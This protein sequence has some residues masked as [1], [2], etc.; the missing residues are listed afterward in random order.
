M[1]IKSNFIDTGTTEDTVAVG[2]HTH[3]D[4]QNT[5]QKNIADGYAGLDSN[6]KILSDQLPNISMIGPSGINSFIACTGSNTYRG[7]GFT[8][9]SNT[10][11]LTTPMTDATFLFCNKF[12][13]FKC[14]TKTNVSTF[15]IN[16]IFATSST[17]LGIYAREFYEDNSSSSSEFRV[18]KYTTNS[19]TNYNII[20]INDYWLCVAVWESN[21]QDDSDLGIYS[22]SVFTTNL[23]EFRVNSHT[24]GKQSNPKVVGISANSYIVTW[25]SYIQDDY[26]SSDSN[27]YAR[28]CGIDTLVGTEFRVSSY[29]TDKQYSAECCS[30]YNFNGYVITWISNRQDGFSNGIYAQR[31]SNNNFPHGTE[32]RVNSYTYYDQK[33]HKICSLFNGGY[34]IVWQSDKQDESSTGIYSKT[35]DINNNIVGDL[36]YYFKGSNYLS[37]PKIGIA[38]FGAG[39]SGNHT[40]DFTI[41]FWIYFGSNVTGR[42]LF[43]SPVDRK[44]LYIYSANNLINFRFY[45][46]DA[47]TSKS[48]TVSYNEWHYILL[49]RSENKLYCFKNGVVD[50]NINGV[51]TIS[52]LSGT[53][54]TIFIGGKP[55]NATNHL[56]RLKNYRISKGIARYTA[57]FIVPDRNVRLL[58]DEYTKL[59][60][61][62]DNNSEITT[63]YATGTSN[64]INYDVVLD[65][66]EFRVNTNT[67]GR[68]ENPSI[69]SLNASGYVIIWQSMNQHTSDSN[70]DIYAQRYNIDNTLYGS[71]FKINS[72]FNNS[73][74]LPKICGLGDNY[75]VVWQ[76]M[77]QHTSNSGYDIYAQ[78]FSNNNFPYGDEFKVNTYF[79]SSQSTPDICDLNDGGY[80]IAWQSSGQDGSASGIYLQRY[81]MD[82]SLFGTEFRANTYTDSKQEAPKICRYDPSY[83]VMWKS[84]SRDNIVPFKNG[85]SLII[86]GQ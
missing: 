22:K 13:E 28:V 50:T 70:W 48:I 74:E 86:I 66:V 47:Y 21:G 72:Y 36:Q 67:I 69:C 37:V 80:I 71:E 23:L 19:Q 18:N 40:N 39:V 57:N 27:I 26:D 34:V 75:V 73:Q 10:I 35:Y 62:L 56:M 8:N 76:S 24:T 41:D 59:L 77:N 25:E 65:S 32:F 82:N 17:N 64:I 11:T 3:N 79:N 55:D 9:D 14:I 60:L 1:K 6:G 51:V 31:Y 46:G 49:S 63:N 16:T 78:R 54:E 4:Y 81:N 85:D 52:D 68:Q 44:G 84:D 20:S 2:N 43:D 42:I 61:H 12:G 29:T 15:D 38:D 53:G 7:F 58:T 83:I 33:S 5:S 45:N 30:L